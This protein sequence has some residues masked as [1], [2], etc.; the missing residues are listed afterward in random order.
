MWRKVLKK[1]KFLLASNDEFKSRIKEY[2]DSSV[3][4]I[5]KSEDYFVDNI[6]YIIKDKNNP[7]WI[8][9]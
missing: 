8:Y 5:G 1:I 6:E 7:D 2:R 9:V 4:N 3:Y